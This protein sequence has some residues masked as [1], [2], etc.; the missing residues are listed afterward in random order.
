LLFMTV[1]MCRIDSDRTAGN[2]NGLATERRLPDSRIVLNFSV[3][4]R[5]AIAADGCSRR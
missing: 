1:P 3:Y 4:R 5:T 2:V